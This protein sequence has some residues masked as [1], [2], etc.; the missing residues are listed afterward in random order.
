MSRIISFR[1][2]AA[3]ILSLGL[4]ILG[5]INIQQKRDWIS[6]DDGAAWLETEAGVIEATMVLSDGPAA[7]AGVEAGD[8]LIRISGID[9][10][11]DLDVT[12]VLY[13]LGAWSQAEYELERNG[14]PLRATTVV[15]SP[16]PERFTRQYGYLEVIGILYLLVGLLVVTR[17]WRAP[18]AM[19]FYFV[20]LMSFVFYVF[21]STG[22]FN[23]FDW[24]IYWADLAAWVFLPP[25][26]MHF[27]LEFPRRNPAIERYRF[28]LPLIYVPAA[29]LMFAGVLF[30]LGILTALPSQRAL[31][32]TLDNLNAIHFGVLFVLS[33]G[34]LLHTYRGVRE[35][36]VRQQM[37]WVTRGTL[38][39][40]VPYFLLQSLP[41]VF[42]FVPPEIFDASVVPLVV[43][44]ISFG[45]AIHRYRLMDVD[46]LF[47]RG[48]AYT[49][50]T[51]LVL[52]LYVT[53]FVVVGELFGEGLPQLGVG[54]SILVMVVAALLFAPTKDR[55][56]VWLDKFF[57]K[58]RYN[59]RLT[60]TDFGSRLG[61]EVDLDKVLDRIVE[62]VS[63]SLWVEQMAVLLEDPDDPS[64]FVLARSR[65]LD[66]PAGTVFPSLKKDIDQPYVILESDAA[67]EAGL[68]YFIP[69]RAKD[70][71]I[72]YLGMGQTE[73]GGY[74]NSEDLKLLEGISDYVGIAVENA[75]LYQSLEDKATQYEALKDFNENIIESI[76]VGVMVE[77]AGKI[78]G[79]NRALEQLTGKVRTEML[80]KPTLDVIPE[81]SLERLRE[82]R[83]LYKHQ[84]G[85]L[86]VNF[87]ATPLVDKEGRTNGRLI[88]VDDI[89]DRV[90]LED[91][92]VQN[93]K[94]TSIG[95][96]AAGVAHEVNTPLA[97]ISSHS[98][99]LRKQLPDD[100]DRLSVMD[101]IIKQTFRA[102]EIV[103][104]LLSFSRTN[105]TE[106][107]ELD[108]HQVIA[109]TLSLLDH[110]LR[111]SGIK[112]QR[113]FT[114][115]APLAF[116]NAGKLQQV[117][118]NL[119]LNA[120]D[121][122]S[123]GGALR[124]RS[125]TTDAKLRIWIEDTGVGISSEDIKKIY[126]PF[127]TTKEAGKGTGL[128]LSVSYGI[129]Q[130]HGGN[131]EVESVPGQGTTF[132]LELPLA[133]KP[134]NA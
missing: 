27:C 59:L 23:D 75:K 105:P 102:S 68:N 67:T 1:L 93:D 104:S 8:V 83:N 7:R 127:F 99:L 132:R 74:L 115:G 80:G 117:F 42:G 17:R 6:P 39:A 12:K 97:V 129:V 2:V 48:A 35:P 106:F 28:L 22:K 72:A 46:T 15:L 10:E 51:M 41:R 124:V 16:Q 95:L 69:C 122:M 88:I 87:S 26:F 79:W 66:M 25:L 31:R 100:D 91:Q 90:R 113:D 96:L 78:A 98:Q 43:I 110:Q 94:L 64:R 5:G 37:K 32:D 81:Q 108:V 134:V 111:S 52:G 4:I 33:A 89:T 53:A 118:L 47:R 50:A 82:E 44:P 107:V 49:L 40:V 126:D 20:C 123:G 120:R 133:R 45:W 29:A 61:S 60:V 131:I 70:R 38:V 125:D 58:D 56:Q 57:Y 114:A 92:I 30:V 86:V 21:H 65:N 13:D 76:S 130:E 9:I 11:N 19:H 101:K 34:V 36:E 18:H 62:R 128:G 103:N 24:T 63:T 77:V 85:D 54:G 71:V 116:G 3:I 55:I 84:W 112:V 109:E 119:F 14:V 73:D 121:A